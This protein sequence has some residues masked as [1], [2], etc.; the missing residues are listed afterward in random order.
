MNF[1]A[2]ENT[3]F[4]AYPEQTASANSQRCWNWFE[5][6]HQNRDQGEPSLIAG[7]ARQIASEYA[8][9]DRRIYIAGLSAGGAAA[10]VLEEAYPDIFAAVGVHSGLACGL[11]RDMPSAFAAMQGRH[12]G[13]AQTSG[14]QIPTI[15][16]HGDRD[17]T[18]HPKNGVE[19][20][21][22]AAAAG[23]YQRVTDRGSV[24]SGRTYT[25]SVHRD[26]RGNDL[27]EDWVIHGGGHAW[28][29]GSTAGSYT[30]PK[31]PDASRE[32]LRFF[33]KHKR[34]K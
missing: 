23:R 9:D 5:S 15:V 21:A 8:I 11:A 2:E 4:V 26:A 1:V 7:I 32:M 3:C 27:I 13:A 31:G 34:A 29:G 12:S 25:R 20:V 14:K 16:F 17:S 22:R 19:V 33:L 28:S 30:D 6:G 24:P 10:A 18:V